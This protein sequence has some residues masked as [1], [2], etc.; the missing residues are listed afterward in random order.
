MTLYLTPQELLARVHIGKPVE[1]WLSYVREADYTVIKWIVIDHE[2]NQFSLTYLES[3]D[4]GDEEF[5]DV[6]EFSVTDPE[7]EPYGTTHLF[8]S[9]EAA[10]TFAIENYG[11]SADKFV[12]FAM[13]EKEYQKY[14]LERP[15]F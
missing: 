7:D 2:E 5:Y 15:R 8:D 3:F 10:V 11:A 12:A 6:H 13:I 14:L 1:Q 9:V 4:E